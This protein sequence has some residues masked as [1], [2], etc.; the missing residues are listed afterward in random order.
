MHLAFDQTSDIDYMC[1][2]KKEEV[3]SPA[4]KFA[5]KQQFKDTKNTLE[6]A[7]KDF[8]HQSVTARTKK[9]KKKNKN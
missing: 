9:N 1:Q 5:M 8:V 2:E 6:I 4:L 7:Q 3:D